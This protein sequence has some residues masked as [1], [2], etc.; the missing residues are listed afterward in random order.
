MWLT[1]RDKK[2]TITLVTSPISRSVHLTLDLSL[3]CTLFLFDRLGRIHRG[4]FQRREKGNERVH[5]FLLHQFLI[6][7]RHFLFF[8]FLLKSLRHPAPRVQDLLFQLFRFHQIPDIVQL[9]P[10]P[11]PPLCPLVCASCSIPKGPFPV[12]PPRQTPR[13]HPARGT[14]CRCP[15]RRDPR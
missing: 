3:G 12:S 14:A 4:I 2:S 13:R 5:F 7:V 15:P 8:V 1:S 10:P 11:S 6:F 9:R